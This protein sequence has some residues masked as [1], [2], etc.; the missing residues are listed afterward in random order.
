MLKNTDKRL[1][2][3]IF[4]IYITMSFYVMIRLT[5]DMEK[6]QPIGA[7]TSFLQYFARKYDCEK[8]TMGVRS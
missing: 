7:Y 8:F 6:D 3:I 1:K 2:E 5:P 4:S